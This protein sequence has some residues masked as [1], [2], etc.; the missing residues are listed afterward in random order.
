MILRNSG[1]LLKGCDAIQNESLANVLKGVLLENYQNFC[2]TFLRTNF[3]KA[4]RLK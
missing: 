1:L 3:V 2:Y 4:K